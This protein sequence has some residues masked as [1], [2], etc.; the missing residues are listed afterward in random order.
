MPSHRIASKFRSSLPAVTA[1]LALALSTGAAP[2]RGTDNPVCA[3]SGDA[4]VA[5][6]QFV[7][8]LEGEDGK[9]TGIRTLSSLAWRCTGDGWKIVREHHSSQVVPTDQI[10]AAMRSASVTPEPGRN[11][12]P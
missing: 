3:T 9:V 11:H 10:D 8:R 2:A 7:A 6:L 5:T 4:A 1:V 12:R